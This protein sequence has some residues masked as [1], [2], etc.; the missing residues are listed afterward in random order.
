MKTLGE[1]LGTDV[2][3]SAVSLGYKKCL[4]RSREKVFSE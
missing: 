4:G 3:L 1:T 2:S